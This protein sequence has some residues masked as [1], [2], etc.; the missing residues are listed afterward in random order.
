V[1]PTRSSVG[2]GRLGA[3]ALLAWVLVAASAGPA[4]ADFRKAYNLLQQG[5][6]NAALNEF[7]LVKEQNPSWYFPYLGLGSCYRRMGKASE[8]KAHLDKALELAK[9][10]S[11]KADVR[12]E[13]AQLAKSQGSTVVA[14]GLLD[15]AR[16]VP[17]SDPQRLIAESL[18]GELL[19]S[20]KKYAEAVSRLQAAIVLQ[21]SD[22]NLRYNLGVAAMGAGRADLAADSFNAAYRL[23]PDQPDLGYLLARTQLQRKDYSAA[24]APALKYESE[25]PRDPKALE[26]AG[27]ALLGQKR[28]ADAAQRFQALLQLDPKSG[29]AALNLAQC[30]G[31]TGRWSESIEAAK[32]AQANGVQS[33]AVYDL[34][35]KGYE[36]LAVR[37]TK[38]KERDQN[39]AEAIKAFRTAQ[40]K[41]AQ[42]SDDLARIAERQRRIEEDLAAAQNQQ[43]QGP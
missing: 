1:R 34:L 31:F 4:L 12:L 38:D 18:A 30:L 24:L 14:L 2:G 10:E 33:A 17:L 20:Q 27:Q 26:L 5:N 36:A 39:L 11:E 43:S 22:F 6:L 35:G 7:A 28:F 41:G 8:A 40:Q 19:L 3:A 13:L 21:P 25:N 15:Q 16:S 29:A 42:V 32:R 9:S 23:K 37:A